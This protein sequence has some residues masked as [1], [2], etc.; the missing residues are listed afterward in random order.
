MLS[1][2]S[3]EFKGFIKFC[4]LTVCKVR[5]LSCQQGRK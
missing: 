2:R 3:A 4:L 5:A 1:S